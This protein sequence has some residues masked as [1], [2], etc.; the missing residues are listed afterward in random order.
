MNHTLLIHIGMPKTGSTAL[1]NFLLTNNHILEKYGW[2]YPIMSSGEIGDLERLDL[3]R[4][5]NGYYLFESLITHNIKS[6]WDKQMGIA[7][8]YLYS[9]NVII[10]SEHVYERG[11]EKFIAGVREKFE[12]I[13][14]VIYLRRQDRTIESLYNQLIKNGEEYRSFDEYLH[15]N[16]VSKDFLEYQLKLGLISR[17]IGRE[18]LIVRVYEKQQLVGNDIITDFLSVLGIPSDKDDWERGEFPNLSL[19]GNYLEL[20]RLIN[21]VQSMN[22]YLGGQNNIWRDTD[23]R[24]DFYDVCVG[25]SSFFNQDNREYGFFSLDERKKFVGKFA[26]DNE[27][28]A[29][30]YLHR[31]DGILFYDDRMNYPVFEPGRDNDFETDMIRVFT[32]MLYVQNQ[33]IKNLIEK[34]NSELLGKLLMK[35]VSK[36]RNNRELLLFGAGRNCRKLFDTVINISASFIVDNDPIKQGMVLGGTQV[37]YAKDIKDWQEYFVI[38]TCEKTDEIEEQLR[39]CNLEKEEDYILIKEYSLWEY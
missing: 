28:I 4:C 10:S 38:V 20:N 25:L 8:N 34:K 27:Q 11:T 13:K 29:R 39:S 26:S 32:A 16:D 6:E 35:D 23:I 24:R 22:G 5:G 37:K 21:S 12:N 36:K 14:V 15:S 18:N 9:N 7:L 2:C 3:E 30:E 1:Q 19:R 31:D 17:I 33:R